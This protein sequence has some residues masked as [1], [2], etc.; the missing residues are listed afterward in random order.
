[1]MSL[2]LAGERFVDGQLVRPKVVQAA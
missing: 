2:V 1:V